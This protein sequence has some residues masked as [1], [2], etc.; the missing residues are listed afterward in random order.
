MARTGR[1]IGIA[2]LEASVRLAVTGTTGML[3][4]WFAM[5]AAARGHQVLRVQRSPDPD[6]LVVDL[7]SAGA[8]ATIIAREPDWVINCAALTNVDW[9]EAHPDRTRL[10]NA[11]VPG[12]LAAAAGTAGIGMVQIST[13]SV[14][15]GSR[16]GYRETDAPDPLNAYA[17]AKLEG[18]DQVRAALE[19]H[20]VLRTAIY[21]WSPGGGHSLSEWVLGRLDAG[22]DVPGFTNAIFSPMS[23]GDLSTV[24]LDLVALE[25]TG[26]WHAGGHDACSKY[27][28]SRLVA[29]AFGHIPERVYPV[30]MQDAPGRA[31]RPLD[32][33]LDSQRLEQRLGREMPMV[34]DGVL[35]WRQSARAWLEG[36]PTRAAGAEEEP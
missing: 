35:R 8:A 6:A 11:E 28:F 15:D 14:F 21:G 5:V 33:S 19:R 13:D 20:V 23:I 10:V 12:R 3:G 29:E 1:A 18:E 36:T 22:E 27:E 26:L 16:G 7:T 9:C 17:R 2:R 34:R 25:A 31:T 32:T 30:P 24:I 4:A